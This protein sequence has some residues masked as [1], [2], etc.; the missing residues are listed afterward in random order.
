MNRAHFNAQ[1]LGM[2]EYFGKDQSESVIQIY[3][4]ALKTLTDEQFTKAVTDAVMKS[5]FFPRIAELIKSVPK[6]KPMQI[7]DKGGLSWCPNTQ[8]LMDKYGPNAKRVA[9]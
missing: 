1:F 5:T 6:P 9:A 8:R 3:W 7:E 4:D 2:C